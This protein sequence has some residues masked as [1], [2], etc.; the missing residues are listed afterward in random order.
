M[1]LREAHVSAAKLK[2]RLQALEDK[3]TKT[4]DLLTKKLAEAEALLADIK[5]ARD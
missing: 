2:Q 3:R 5:N 1:D 4:A